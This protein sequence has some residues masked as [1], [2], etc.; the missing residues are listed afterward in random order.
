MTHSLPMTLPPPMTMKLS[1]R[2]RSLLC[3]L[4]PCHFALPGNNLASLPPPSPIASMVAKPHLSLMNTSNC[5]A[6]HIR[7]SSLSGPDGTVTWQTRCHIK[8]HT[9][10]HNLTHWI[11]SNNWI[12]R[13]LQKNAIKNQFYSKNIFGVVCELRGLRRITVEVVDLE[14]DV[15][16]LQAQNIREGLNR[17]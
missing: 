9:L 15:G 17:S 12:H 5:S 10:I 1:F 16:V 8:L 7:K 4:A 6:M 14:G 11:A 13:F 3:M 2:L